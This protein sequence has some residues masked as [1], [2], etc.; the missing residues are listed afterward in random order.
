MQRFD[1]FEI[2]ATK[3]DEGFI[4]DCPIIGRVG[5]LEYINADGTK[6][7]EYRPPEEA[8]NADSLESIA[9]KPITLG[10]KG[11][12]NAGNAGTI[13]PIGSVLTAGKQDGDNIRAD[14]IIYNLDSSAR[15]LSCGY[16]LEL[17]MTP[18]ITPD[19]QHYDAVQRKIRYNHLA[20]VPRGR[21]GNARLNMDGDQEDIKEGG[22]EN[23]KIRLDS[24]LEYEAAP[25]VGVYVEK[26][27]NDASAMK[28]EQDALQ[29]KYDSVLADNEKL[30][31][32]KVDAEAKHKEAFDAAVKARVEMLDAAKKF[33]IENADGMTDKD[34]KVAII[35]SVRG[36]SFNLDGK[37]EDYIAAAF[38]FALADYKPAENNNVTNSVKQVNGDGK[39]N[40]AD[41]DELDPAK[42]LAKLQEDE[43]GLW[44]KEVK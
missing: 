20:I 2:K 19:G 15:E 31:K 28:K 38:E 42:A 6:H 3:T 33:K 13:K 37:S 9:G 14:V 30:K 8:F 18:G 32:E 7:I 11:M 41:D 39:K 21:A 10:H 1:R 24:G 12:V 40:N 29:A 43:A 34:I 36:D 35:K 22:N 17:D 25:E 23:M 27:R 16:S 5:L 4:K 44:M 26:L